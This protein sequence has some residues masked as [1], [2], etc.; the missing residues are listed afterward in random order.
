[1][2]STGL[3]LN[4]AAPTVA[5]SIDLTPSGINLHSGHAFD[6]AINYNGTNL[7][8]K[9]TDVTT[10][11]SATQ[12]YLVNLVAQ[13]GGSTA[14][15]GFTAATGGLTAVQDILSWTYTP[16]PRAP[17]NLAA[18]SGTGNVALAWSSSL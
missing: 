9:I 18:T 6:V 5:N 3:Y 10:G 16:V 17:G 4:G 8:V 7:V 12:T 11:V 1:A 2:N 15:V 13:I 14:Y